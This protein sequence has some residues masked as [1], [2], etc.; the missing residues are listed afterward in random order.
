MTSIQLGQTT[1]EVY[2][3]GPLYRGEPKLDA[4]RWNWWR[5]QFNKLV[6][7]TGEPEYQEVA[8]KMGTMQE[9]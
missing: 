2:E 5:T 9:V 3:C 4:K 7:A 1:Y 8:S 6:A